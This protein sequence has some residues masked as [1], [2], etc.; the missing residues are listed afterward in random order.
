MSTTTTCEHVTFHM[1]N[2][3]NAFL[4]VAGVLV[5]DPDVV[6]TK[7]IIPPSAF[8]PINI[9][10]NLGSPH[11]SLAFATFA[12]NGEIPTT[13]SM[14]TLLQASGDSAVITV[15]LDTANCTMSKF[16]LKTRLSSVKNYTI[17]AQHDDDIGLQTLILSDKPT[18]LNTEVG[19][20][21]Y[22]IALIIAGVVLCAITL[23]VHLV[24]AHHYGHMYPGRIIRE[25][26][27]KEWLGEP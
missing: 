6:V 18:S 12:V 9:A 4:V 19:I 13:T 7:V 14:A 5:D 10:T 20:P 8:I 15:T 24:H 17:I 11:I 16:P 1:S 3:S 22:V 2:G 27:S 25:Q 21:S 26:A 23:T